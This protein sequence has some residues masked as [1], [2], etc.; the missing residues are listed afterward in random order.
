MKKL[1]DRTPVIIIGLAFI[2]VGIISMFSMAA[3]AI[4]KKDVVK[5][6]RDSLQIV[7][8]SLQVALNVKQMELDNCKECCEAH[9]E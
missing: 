9:N 3:S 6:S 2:A 4:V 1:K 7:A 8:D 5:E